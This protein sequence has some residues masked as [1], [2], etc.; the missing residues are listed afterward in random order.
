MKGL[1]GPLV[2]GEQGA[3]F[4]NGVCLKTLRHACRE[5]APYTPTNSTIVDALQALEVLADQVEALAE[6]NAA[7]TA[8]Q[9][10]G[11]K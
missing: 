9:V 8:Q 7:L 6:E 4:L 10:Q 11:E 1:L 2:R 3:W 5:P